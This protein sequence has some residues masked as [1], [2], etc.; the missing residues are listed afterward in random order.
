MKVQRLVVLAGVLSLAGCAT[1][2]PIQTA[3]GKPD[4]VIRGADRA[5]VR[6]GMLNGLL[7][8][9]FAVRTANDLQVVVQRPAPPSFAAA[10]LT[11][12]YGPPEQRVAIT[13]VPTGSDLRVVIDASVVSN[14]GT[15]FERVQPYRASAQDQEVFEAMARRAE[16]TCA[17]K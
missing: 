4:V 9:G 3:S 10:M 11:T 12:G 14:S 17:R 7:T 15:A 5:C 6:D 1:A 2:P 8:N 16:T 13:M